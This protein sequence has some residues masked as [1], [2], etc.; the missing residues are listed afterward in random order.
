MRNVK[1][2]S[3]GMAEARAMLSTHPVLHPHA[4][5]EH[6]LA[7]ASIRHL[8][9]GEY[10]FR[11]DQPADYWY[12][13]VQGRVDTLRMG[14]DGEDRIIHH[15]Q[16]GQLLAAIVMFLQQPR[17]PVEARAAVDSTLCRITRAALH[18]A[19]LDYPALAMGML[20]LAAQTVT[21][22]IDDVDTLA[23][24]TAQQRLAAYLLRLGTVDGPHVELPV[25]QRQLAARLGVRAETLNRLL[26]E[27]QRLGYLAGKGRHWHV[28]ARAALEALA[29]GTRDR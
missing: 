29:H 15:V 9:K 2:A 17:Y 21:L 10:V 26:S 25:S 11:Q 14:I 27:W 1:T 12:V 7:R 16:A 4:V 13:V 20:Q 24:T 23:S 8:Q 19:C 5:S 22:R 3:A 18:R 28:V 6:L